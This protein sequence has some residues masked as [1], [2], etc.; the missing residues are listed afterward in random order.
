MGLVVSEGVE[1][2]TI[3]AQGTA[4]GRQEGPGAVA[5]RLQF[6]TQARG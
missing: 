3:A 2:M 5:E 6:E 4:V 1:S